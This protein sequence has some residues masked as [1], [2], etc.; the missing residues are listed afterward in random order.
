MTVATEKAT[1]HVLGWT[2]GARAARAVAWSS[3]LVGLLTVLAVVFRPVGRRL[4]RPLFDW[5][6]PSV[7][8]HVAAG[9]VTVAAGIGLILVGAGLR[10]R[11]RR[12]WQLAV[13]LSALVLLLHLGSDRGW[14]AVLL[15]VALLAVLVVER[16]RFVALPDPVPGKWTAIVVAAELLLI[17]A[18][19]DTLILLVN[20]HELVG[21]PG[22]AE[23]V[24]QVLL[25]LVGVSGP[26]VFRREVIDDL[27]A[28]IGLWSTIGAVLAG[29]YFLLR[30]AEPKPALTAEDEARVRALLRLPGADS[31]GYFALRRDKSIVFSPSGKAAV[32]YRVLAGVALSTGD[33]LGD[34]EAWPAALR[35]FLHGCVEHAW[36]PAV[37]GCSEQAATAWAR[38]GLTVLELGDEAVVAPATFTLVGRRMRG[39]RQAVARVGRLGY[40]TRVRR[41]AELGAAERAEL[42]RLASAWRGTATERGFAMALSRVAGPDD[43]D[44]VLVTAERDGVVHGI[45]QFVPWGATGL[46]LDLMRRDRGSPDNGLTEFMITELLAACPG[47]G[48]DRVSLNFA[49]FRSALERGR[50]IGAGPVARRWAAALRLGSRWWQIES[51]YRFN[52]KFRPTWVPR[53]LVFPRTR[54]LPRVVLAAMEA[55]GFGGRPP[56]VLRV[57]RR[58]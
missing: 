18:G 34:V 36:V 35:Q 23:R 4:G 30:S 8:A 31:L 15:T 40:V 7:P 43:P 6:D 47:L 52:D 2:D 26:L 56:A 58:R 11:K 55:E 19:A 44:C 9:T 13:G 1:T 39:V 33:P 57:L 27:T 50:R 16:E 12:A 49:M 53:Y 25:A 28:T 17:G 14:I 42:D 48:V 32:A 51:L 38:H 3:R 54:D 20:R 41:S 5:I 45:L 10:R 24:E 29:G 46:S 37:V 22:L 21:S